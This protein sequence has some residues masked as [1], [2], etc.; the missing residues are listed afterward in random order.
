M[1]FG[2]FDYVE[3]ARPLEIADVFE[4]RLQMLE[5][6][7]QAGYY[8]Y[9]LAEHHSTPLSMVPSPNVFLAA[10]A[11][12]T[13]RIRLGTLVYLLPL[14]N[15]LR[16]IDEICMLDQLSRGRLEVGVGRSIQPWELGVYNIRFEDSRPIFR[17]ALDILLMGLATGAV[18]YEGKYLS[19]HDVPVVLRPYQR[20]YPPLWYPTAGPDT[21]WMAQ[22]GFNTIAGALF[23]PVRALPER[24]S[25]YWRVQRAHAQ[26]AQRI[27]AHVSDPK[28]GFA[29]HIYVAETDA[30]AEQAARAAY[31]AFYEN[32]SWLFAQHGDPYPERQRDFDGLVQNG[33]M[34]FGS[35]AT[36]RARLQETMDLIGGNYFA[37]VFAWGSLGTERI[38]RSLRLFAEEVMP[39]VKAAAP[40]E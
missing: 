31:P 25:A 13:R 22:Q 18:D 7:D 39:A 8:C 32:F 33:L 3:L 36:V 27:N 23:T 24:V 2:I 12:R 9:H 15:P 5:Y 10:A 38:M 17:E 26:D 11:Q 6:A 19:F 34:L 16:L 4:Q 21:E 37:G 28:Y 35:P 14:Y 30:E 40:R 1:Q 20:P 29:C